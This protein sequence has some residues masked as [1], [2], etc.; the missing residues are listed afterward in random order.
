M[1]SERCMKELQRHTSSMFDY[2]SWDDKPKTVLTFSH[3][4][5]LRLKSLRDHV[6]SFSVD[7][8]CF[9]GLWS[10]CL[11]YSRCF[12]AIGIVI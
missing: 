4:H 8:G 5:V 7:G 10:S 11:L 6:S 3:S 2:T 1:N 12:F 9:N